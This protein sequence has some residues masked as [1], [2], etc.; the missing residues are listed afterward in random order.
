M[1]EPFL[2]MLEEIRQENFKPLWVAVPDTVGDKEKTLENWEKYAP[3]C[4]E[5]GHPLAFV[6][7]D[8]ME[9]SDVPTE[10]SVVFLGGSF[11]WKWRNAE[12]FCGA[13][14]RVHIGRVNTVGKLWRAAEMGAESVDGTGWVRRGEGPD[15]WRSLEPFLSGKPHD[16]LTLL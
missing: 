13:F 8:G 3:I 5:Y 10:A 16:Q 9:P 7:Q 1:E 6:A 2:L 15:G 14:P 4:S 12:T 11:R